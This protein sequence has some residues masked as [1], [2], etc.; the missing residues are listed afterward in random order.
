MI[1]SRK[2]DFRA[3][4]PK[5]PG[6]DQPERV[7][8]KRS[9]LGNGMAIEPSLP[10]LFAGNSTPD[11]LHCICNCEAIFQLSELCRRCLIQVVDFEGLQRDEGVQ[12]IE[13]LGSKD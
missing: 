12:L 7:T 13:F 10:L 3:F 2:I 1:E 8:R 4:A 6:P 5:Y 11:L 9:G